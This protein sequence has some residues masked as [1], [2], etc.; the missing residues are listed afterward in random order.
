MGDDV[1]RDVVQLDLNLS[2]RI[3]ASYPICMV[4]GGNAKRAC[5]IA[6]EG[7]E[8]IGDGKVFLTC[9]ACYTLFLRLEEFQKLGL[10][11]P[12]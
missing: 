4:C 11:R 8:T 12:P 9:S 2:K 7:G 1:V 6:L 3:P 10:L 5:T